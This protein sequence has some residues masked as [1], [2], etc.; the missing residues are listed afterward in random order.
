MLNSRP[1]PLVC[2]R[3]ISFTKTTQRL[4]RYQRTLIRFT[5]IRAFSYPCSHLLI[6]TWEKTLQLLPC[7]PPETERV[8]YGPASLIIIN[9]TL[10]IN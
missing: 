2:F 5:L 8:P 7:Y 6:E 10:T 9:F 3:A 4:H 1:R